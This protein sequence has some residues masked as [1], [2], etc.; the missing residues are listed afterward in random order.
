ML[1]VLAHITQNEVSGFWMAALIGF[2]AGV[3]VAYGILARKMK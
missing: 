1:Q 2:A 3:A